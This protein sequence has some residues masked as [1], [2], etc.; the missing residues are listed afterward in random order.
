LKIEQSFL[1]QFQSVLRQ[2]N[3]FLNGVKIEIILQE[4]DN[5][6]DHFQIRLML[7]GDFYLHFFTQRNNGGQWWIKIK[8]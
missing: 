8:E 2:K 7:N 6:L 3:Y 5:E 1:G 4:Q